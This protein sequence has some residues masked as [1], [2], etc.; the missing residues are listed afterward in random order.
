VKIVAIT[1]ATATPDAVTDQTN[2]GA[3]A[4]TVYSENSNATLIGPGVGT[5]TLFLSF[6]VEKTDGSPISSIRVG[7]TSHWDQ[8]ATAHGPAIQAMSSDRNR[9]LEDTIVSCGW[10]KLFSMFPPL[11][12]V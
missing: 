3:T 2:Q 4:A 7:R 9:R 6:G 12:N 8:I 5:T 10:L 11:P 1:I